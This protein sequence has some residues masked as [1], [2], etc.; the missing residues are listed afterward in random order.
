MH[1]REFSKETI[2][3]QEIMRERT[4]YNKADDAITGP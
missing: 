2:D 4:T 3:T 1:N